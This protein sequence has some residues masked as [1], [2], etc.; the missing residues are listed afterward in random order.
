MSHTITEKGTVT[1]P[2]EMRRKH[3][4]KKG[5]KVRFVDTE[6]GPL[7]VPILS[8]NSLHGIDKNRKD[9]VYRM[10]RELHAERRKEAADDG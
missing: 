2:V 4:L 9:I 7:I 8:L 5:S 1:I 10:I 3:N 6:Q